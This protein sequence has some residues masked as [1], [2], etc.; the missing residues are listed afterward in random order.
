LPVDILIDHGT[1][2]HG[3]SDDKVDNEY[4]GKRVAKYFAVHEVDI[5]HEGTVTSA[6]DLY[7][8]VYDD[9]DVEDMNQDELLEALR[10]YRL[11]YVDIKSR[12]VVDRKGRM[13]KATVHK[14]RATGEGE[15]VQVH[16]DGNKESTKSWI[17]I[18]LIHDVFL[19]NDKKPTSKR[20][21]SESDFSGFANIHC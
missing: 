8:A 3:A 7:H 18:S 14:G 10:L 21:V 19:S 16:Y 6:D 20:S 1:V 5:L 2:S 13:C 17:P 15:Q 9:G 11:R 4:V 12:V